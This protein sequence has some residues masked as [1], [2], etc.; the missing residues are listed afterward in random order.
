LRDQVCYQNLNWLAVLV[1]CRHLQLDEALARLRLE[2]GICNTSLSS[3]NVSPGYGAFPLE[4]IE[5]C[6]H[7]TA[8]RAER[9]FDKK[10]HGD[11]S[12]M[13]TA[14]ASPPKK[15]PF[16]PSPAEVEWLRVEPTGE[17]DDL[18]LIEAFGSGPEC[19]ADNEV[20]QEKAHR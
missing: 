20:F 3:R 9:A 17:I 10:E 8:R 6:S 13:P 14:R 19:L 2:G 12:S 5:P 1:Q 7:N 15:L 16:A 4:L 18:A 11:G